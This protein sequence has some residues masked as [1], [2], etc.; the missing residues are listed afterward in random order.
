MTSSWPP[1][2]PPARPQ[3]RYQWTVASALS[4]LRW[5]PTERRV[6]AVDYLTAVI[7]SGDGEQVRNIASALLN[8]VGELTGEP[9]YLAEEETP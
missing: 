7:L 2:P 3:Y 6:S 8:L 9:D 5:E 4:Q 1:Q